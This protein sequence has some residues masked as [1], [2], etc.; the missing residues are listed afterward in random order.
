MKCPECG[1]H[2]IQVI[3]SRDHDV[4]KRRRRRCMSSQ[5]GLTFT[6]IEVYAETRGGR[7]QP[8]RRQIR[9]AIDTLYGHLD[10]MPVEQQ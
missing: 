4:V 3:D 6:T 8:L 7:R 2:N 1:S 5:C 9:I 10:A